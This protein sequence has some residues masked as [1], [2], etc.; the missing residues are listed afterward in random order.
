VFRTGVAAPRGKGGKNE[1]FFTADVVVLWEEGEETATGLC[2]RR[3]VKFL[4]CDA[5][6]REDMGVTSMT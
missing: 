4:R 5:E 2:R 6:Q 1:G 3:T